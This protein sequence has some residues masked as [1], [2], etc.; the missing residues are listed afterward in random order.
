MPPEAE[1]VMAESTA[2]ELATEISG[3]PPLRSSTAPL[4]SENTGKAAT[5][6]PIRPG[7]RY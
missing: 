4:I 7:S 6:A 5:T 3:L 2:T 1:P